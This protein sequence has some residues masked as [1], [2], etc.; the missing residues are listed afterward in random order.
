MNKKCVE[1]F[2]QQSCP[3]PS[4]DIN[5]K[6]V[7]KVLKIPPSLHYERGTRYSIFQTLEEHSTD[8]VGT[9]QIPEHCTMSVSKASEFSVSCSREFYVNQKPLS[10]SVT[11]SPNLTCL[12]VNGT[13]ISLGFTL[14]PTQNNV[15]GMIVL[16][17]NI[18]F[19]EGITNKEVGI[20]SAVHETWVSMFNEN[21]CESRRRSTKCDVV[22]SWISPSSSCNKCMNITRKALKRTSSSSQIPCKKICT[23]LSTQLLPNNRTFPEQS[24]TMEQN[25]DNV[26]K[27]NSPNE[28]DAIDRLLSAGA[29]E[30]FKVLLES[31][32]K[33]SNIELDIHQ[34]RWN[35]QIISLC[36]S[37]Y[38]RSPN[39][40][41][42]L[43]NSGM[44]ILPAKST[45]NY[46]RN[47]VKQ[48]PGITPDNITWM[49]KE[50]GRQNTSEYGR[51]GGILLDEMSIQDDLQIVRKGDA[52]DIVGGVDM[53]ETN[54]NINIIIEG[55]KTCHL[56]T[57]CLQFAFH[58]FTGFRWPIAYYGSNPASTHQIYN[59]FWEC[60]DVLD[61]NGF[62]VDYVMLDGASTNRSFSKLL[63]G[64]DPRG[65]NF[66]AKDIYDSKHQVCVIQDIKHVFKK[67]RNS[68]E[69]SKRAN[70]SSSGR[71]LVL[72]GR[73]IVWE[74]FEEVLKFNS[75][76]GL[77]IHRK[78]TKEH[79]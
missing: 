67:I 40:Y 32:I 23:P 53:G 27:P 19:C 54:N 1:F 56:A 6:L 42:D 69:S 46:Y 16:M 50:A 4:K 66:V 78:L 43:R 10:C 72:N 62:I 15:D 3:P 17:E 29:P 74:L 35:P 41:E 49:K 5:A 77:R 52:W 13:N 59:N 37:L 76:S 73:P 44:L 63:L 26:P 22:I 71:H 2:N 20:R 12:N 34:R 57:H 7:H 18:K 64:D 70:E 11:F 21:V 24:S 36:L 30:N 68:I 45:L 75:S 39:A 61:E 8:R 33:N 47:S 38:C 28:Q 55:K 79:I 48:V 25:E 65:C 51:R 14:T 58:G 31:Q 9:I 60:V